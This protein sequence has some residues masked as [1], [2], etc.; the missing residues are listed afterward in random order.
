MARSKKRTATKKQTQE[1]TTTNYPGFDCYAYP[2]NATMIA[3]KNPPEPRYP[4]PRTLSAIIICNPTITPMA[5][6]LEPEVRCR[7]VAGASQFFMWLFP[8]PRPISPGH[9]E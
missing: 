6:G 9:A 7:A 5:R 4:Q 3:W 8:P 2:G 1:L